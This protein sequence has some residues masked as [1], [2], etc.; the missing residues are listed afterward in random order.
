MTSGQFASFPVDQIYVNREERQRRELK[1][2]ESL[3]DSI[4]RIGLINPLVVE[5]DGQLRAGERRWTAI[6]SLGWTHVSV[7]FTDE[8]TPTEFQ[9]LELEE[10]IK[11]EQLPWQDECRAVARYHQLH[12][13][14][15][16][17]EGLKWTMD[18]TSEA[19]GIYRSGIVERVSIARELAAG[20]QRVIDAPKMSVARNVVARTNER[21]QQSAVS[22]VLKAASVSGTEPVRPTVPLL[23][24]D[25]HEWALEYKGEPFNFIHC[26]FPY[27]VNADKHDQGQAKT[28]GGYADGF[29]TYDKLLGTL[30]YSMRSVVSDSAHLMFWYSMDYH[31]YT[32]ERLTDMGW[33]VNP[34]PLVW[35]KNDN[36]GILPDPNRGPRRVY[37][38]AFFAS[39]GD[40]KLTSRGAVANAIGWPGRDKSLHMSEKPVGMLK[41]FM[42]MSVDEYSRVLDPTCGSGNALKA[43]TALKAEVVLGLERDD[44][45][46]ERSVAGY[47]RDPEVA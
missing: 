38:T 28:Q 7:Q 18:D 44:E 41:H 27:G 47:W 31:Q 8:L 13:E 9:L 23:H 1:N 14:E 16:E 20:N 10:N 42:G 21:A 22:A 39:R 5:R 19:L 46:Y 12:V 33:R 25:F 15:A 35:F 45:F 6:K 11:R 34:F 17:A 24:V 32:L 40:R 43:A 4:Q 2:I 29:E 26:D 36:T 3:A 37:E 30:G